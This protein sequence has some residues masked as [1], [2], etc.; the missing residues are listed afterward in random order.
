MKRQR[1]LLPEDHTLG[2]AEICNGLPHEPPW[3]SVLST[4]A[5]R[6]YQNKQWIGS[7]P[8][9]FLLTAIAPLEDFKFLKFVL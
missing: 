7:K 8:R 9:K 4:V 5:V 6:E 3:T 2:L 1:K